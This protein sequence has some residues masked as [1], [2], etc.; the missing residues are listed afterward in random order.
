MLEHP[1]DL[2][3]EKSITEKQAEWL[4]TTSVPLRG[5]AFH[6]RSV[7]AYGACAWDPQSETVAADSRCCA[8]STSTL[9]VTCTRGK[10][11]CDKG[12]W[13]PIMYPAGL[14]AGL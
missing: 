8:A 10:Q 14:T 2:V 9:Q 5:V 12:C 13:L 3:F 11:P 1:V 4:A 7:Q 6:R